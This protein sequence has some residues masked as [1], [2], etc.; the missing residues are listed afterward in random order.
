MKFLNIIV[1]MDSHF[2][3]GF[4]GKIPWRVHADMKHFR[5][6]TQD[7]ILIMGRKTWESIP[8]QYQL[9][10]GRD[11]VV[12]V[13]TQL[14][15]EN[16]SATGDRV[17]FVKNLP[18]AIG[19]AWRR[20]NSF[21]P[22]KPVRMFICGGEQ[23]YFEAMEEWRHMLHTLYV[24]I[25]P[26]DFITDV[27]FP[28]RIVSKMNKVSSFLKNS[29]EEIN[30][31]TLFE[32]GQRKVFETNFNTKMRMKN[33]SRDIDLV[34]ECFWASPP[35]QP[36]VD[37]I[38]D[39]LDNGELRQDRTGVGTYSV[40]DK[41]VEFDLTKGFPLLSRRVIFWRGCLEET[42]FFLKGKTNTKELEKKGVNIWK[43]NTSREFL[44]SRGLQDL[45]EGDM[46]GNYGFLW[47]H[48]GADYEGHDKDYEGKGFDQIQYVLHEIKHN[49]TSRRL[50]VSAW[51]P[52][53]E[54]RMSLPSCH[55]LFQFYVRQ[56][57]FLDC[58][59]FQRSCDVMLGLPF[60][61]ASYALITHIFAHKCGL[62]AGRLSL[63]LGDTH[64]YRNHI[65]GANEFLTRPSLCFPYLTLMF[66]PEKPIEEL[67]VED[68]Q[69]NNYA[70]LPPIKMEMA[71]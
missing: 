48:F 41:R 69:L 15:R 19:R 47:R 44:D 55:M 65:Q 22:D 31:P 67:D 7:S 61:I 33:N 17:Q 58:R 49:P 39:I 28:I 2:G 71:V 18:E 35:D 63:L 52:N 45:Q 26:G 10:N 6:V 27:Y 29:A 21:L 38:R 56:G 14:S 53:Q 46:G 51:N 59:M 30:D 13:S 54:H 23:L 64:I 50:I 43:G 34:K 36:Y 25:V 9:F 3:I 62:T 70:G 66:D 4:E 12:V 42:L 5:E 37:I 68:I 32:I 11:G 8:S 40:F 60:N 57:K 20:Y 24:T 16:R 1:A